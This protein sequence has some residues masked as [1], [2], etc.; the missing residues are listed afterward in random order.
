MPLLNALVV[1]TFLLAFLAVPLKTYAAGPVIW[2]E[3]GLTR[4]FKNDPA[5]NQSSLA[6]YS[7][8]NEYE[9]FQI[10]IKV[11][12]GNTL[13]NVRVS[14][15]DFAGP[16]NNKI[17]ADNVSLYREHYVNVTAGSKK[18]AGDTNS[19]LGPG[20]YPDALIPFIDPAT[21]IDL[22]GRLDA[23]PFNVLPSENQP[24]LADIYIPAGTP[25]GQYNSTVTIA[26]GQGTASADVILIVWNFSLP[27]TRSL[28]GFTNIWNTQYK[29]KSS[30]IELLKHRLNPKSV[31]RADE[32]FFID[33]FGLD[34]VDLGLVSGAGY[35]NCNAS[36]PPSQATVQAAVANHEQDLYLLSSYANEVW[37]CTSLAGSFLNWAASL[38]AGGA[39]PMIVTYPADALMGTDLNHTAADVW[40]ILPKHYDT[41]KT[42]IQKLVNHPG[43]QVWFYNPLV[44]EGFSPKFT[45]DFLPINSRIMQG[46][47]NQ[48][49]GARGSKFWR[50]D[51][52]TADPWNN[53]EATRPDA[54]GEG[55]YAYPGADV[56][57]PGIIV[58]S[59]RLKWYR[60]GSEDFEY[61][62][63]LKNAGQGQFALDLAKTVGA[64]FQNWTKDKNLLLSVR[65]KLGEK[66]HSLNLPPIS[67][68]SPPPTIS[69][70]GSS[71]P[72][73][74]N[75][76]NLVDGTDY[77]IWHSKYNQSAL[78]AANGDF[79]NNGFV[80]GPDYVIWLNNYNR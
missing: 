42:N 62:Q 60:E 41:A 16:N 35:Q 40:S 80:D 33:N 9:M 37:D 34:S 59:M 8:G 11:P 31:N 70:T 73:D 2:L 5:K 4:V 67:P 47:I 6:L 36:P 43:I 61:I 63:I 17:S 48:S 66:I 55:H 78:G 12:P 51:N 29:T 10:I 49:L 75:G 74:A 58:P 44:Q 64:D 28:K 69:V 46:F 3:D 45:V 57:L 76:D 68:I 23:S 19:P 26:S 38:R 1:I 50:V 32:R 39:H 25:P 18:R 22:T 56:G 77:S 54:P 21:K 7:A 52:W 14:V 24:V 13:T 30:H 15:S 27:K 20:F 71:K 79:D 65:Q 72:G 53:T